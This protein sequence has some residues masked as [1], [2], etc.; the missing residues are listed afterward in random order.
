[1]FQLRANRRRA[2]SH[3]LRMR[4]SQR[5]GLHREIREKGLP[6]RRALAARLRQLGWRKMCKAKAAGPREDLTKTRRSS[7]HVSGRSDGRRAPVLFN[8]L[9]A[10]L[11]VAD[12]PG[13]AL[14]P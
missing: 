3:A 9:P 4:V 11:N 2:I 7:R 10:P 14:T 8:R 12:R 1:M 6:R 13:L 5:D